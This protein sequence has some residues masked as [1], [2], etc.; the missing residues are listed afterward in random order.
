MVTHTTNF[1]DDAVMARDTILFG[2]FVSHPDAM[3]RLLWQIR[4]SFELCLPF[5]KSVV[6]T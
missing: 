4:S 5:S 1:L 3:F 6:F 2:T